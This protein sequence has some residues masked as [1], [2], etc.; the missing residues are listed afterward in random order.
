M[1]SQRGKT[2]KKHTQGLKLVPWNQLNSSTVLNS[3]TNSQEQKDQCERKNNKDSK[4]GSWNPIRSP[5]ANPT[6]PKPNLTDS[7]KRARAIR[8]KRLEFEIPKPIT[9]RARIGIRS[10]YARLVAIRDGRSH[11]KLG[12][13]SPHCGREKNSNFLSGS[14]HLWP[15]SCC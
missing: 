10:L 13:F 1:N 15:L 11:Q 4:I 5:H 8:L 7:N 2:K 6:Q 14:S 12:F 9:H 3:I